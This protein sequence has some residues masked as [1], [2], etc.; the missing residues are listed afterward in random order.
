MLAVEN[1][2]TRL[3]TDNQHHWLSMGAQRRERMGKHHDEIAAVANYA[4]LTGHRN[5]AIVD[6]ATPDEIADG[7][8]FRAVEFD[9]NGE[10]V[11]A[12]TIFDVQYHYS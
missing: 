5:V 12:R 3:T 1:R 4:A 10:R 7:Y 11:Q 6:D 9:W 8:F 2:A